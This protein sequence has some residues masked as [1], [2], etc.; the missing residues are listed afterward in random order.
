MLK[1]DLDK[2][3]LTKLNNKLKEFE[4]K[5]I[6]KKTRKGLRK[7]A[8][9]FRKKIA[10]NAKQLDDGATPN[11]IWKNVAIRTKKQ[12]GNSS[13]GVFVGIA[14]GAKQGRNKGLGKGGDTFYW[15]FLEFGTSKM[16][17]RPFFRPAIGDGATQ[18]KAMS[19]TV[20]MLQKEVLKKWL[21]FLI[22][23]KVFQL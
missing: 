15:R 1:M 12:K 4:T 13:I 6:I 8:N 22:F 16:R 10:E 17:A 7:G 23:A 3:S 11:A 18:S 9:V 2:S 21:I 20:K 5:E 14:G 19:E